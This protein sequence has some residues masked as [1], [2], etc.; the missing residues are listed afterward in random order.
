MEIIKA[1]SGRS[2]ART[3]AD[4]NAFNH[5]TRS[6]VWRRQRYLALGRPRPSCGAL[7]ASD[8]ACAASAYFGKVRIGQFYGLRIGL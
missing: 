2:G 5:T 3:D 1:V 8:T 6:S 7:V 4:C